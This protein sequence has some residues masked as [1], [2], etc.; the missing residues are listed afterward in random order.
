[1]LDMK[2]VFFLFPQY[3]MHN[4]EIKYAYDVVLF[5]CQ[6]CACDTAGSVS[7]ICDVITGQCPC[8]S[9]T[10]GRQCGLCQNGT[11]GLLASNPLAVAKVKI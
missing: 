2:Y 1:M 4:D 10:T 3:L 5:R 7:N 9:F 11:N 6:S 8:K